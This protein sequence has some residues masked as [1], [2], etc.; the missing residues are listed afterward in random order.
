MPSGGVNID[1][2]GDFIRAGSAVVAAG[3][4]VVDKKAAQKKEFHIIT[5]TIR[6]FARA[7]QEARAQ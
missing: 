1:N 7:I 3:G 4:D 6:A 2:V 5:S